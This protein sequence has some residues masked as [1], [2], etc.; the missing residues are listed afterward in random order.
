[1]SILRYSKEHYVGDCTINASIKNINGI[2][3]MHSHEYYEIEIVLS[4]SGTY[5]VDGVD[6]EMKRGSLFAL[7]PVS[8]HEVE[9]RDVQLINIMFV[10]DACNTD[11][12]MNLFL[13][14]PYFMCT[15]K[16]EDLNFILA[17][18]GE[19]SVH[20]NRV[21]QRNVYSETLLDCV[22]GKLCSLKTGDQL[23]K[24]VSSVQYAFFYMQ[25]HFTEQ[26]RLEDVAK[27]AGY[28]P[29]YFNSCFKKYTGMTFKQYLTE[30]RF[31]FSKKL[32]EYTD[33]SVTEIYTKCGFGDFSH[34]MTEFKKRYGVTPKMYRCEKKV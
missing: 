32:L 22:L 33:L 2:V 30:L 13:T 14:E 19:L 16:E 28:S 15:L 20:R 31:S 29:N 23:P 25:N 24:K 12:V 8:F 5:H 17:L 4:G 7:S 3:T 18:V 26:L 6:Y 27:I 10:I 11:F 34:F 9:F 1:M 21:C